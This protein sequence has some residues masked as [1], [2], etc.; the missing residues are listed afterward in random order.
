VTLTSYTGIYFGNQTVASVDTLTVSGMDTKKNSTGFV[1]ATDNDSWLFWSLECCTAT[2]VF[3]SVGHVLDGI[4]PSTFE[5][6]LGNGTYVTLTDFTDAQFADGDTLT[7]RAVRFQGQNMILNSTAFSI[8]DSAGLTQTFLINIQYYKVNWDFVSVDSELDLYSTLTNFQYV[9][10]NGTAITQ[11]S[12]F[13]NTFLG[14]GTLNPVTLKFKGQGVLVNNT[15]I[16]IDTAETHLIRAQWYKVGFIFASNDHVLNITP[17]HIQFLAPNG[18]VIVFTNDAHFAGHYIGNGTITPH[19]ITYKGQGMLKNQTAIVISEERNHLFNLQY[20]RVT[21]NFVSEDGILD[22]TPTNFKAVVANNTLTPFTATHTTLYLGNGTLTPHVITLHGQNIIKNMTGITIDADET[23]LMRGRYYRINWDFLSDSGTL[24]TNGDEP[25]NFIYTLG[26]ST[27][28]TQTAN[29]DAWYSANQ[30]LTPFSILWD[31]TSIH[32]NQTQFSISDDG[33]IAMRTKVYTINFV[34][35]STDDALTITPD[36]FIMVLSNGTEVTTT[37]PNRASGWLLA[38]GTLTPNKIG[39]QGTNMI[40]NATAITLDSTETH[41]LYMRYYPITFEFMSDD[42]VLTITPTNMTFTGA[43]GTQAT[44]TSFASAVY[45]G[46]Q[47]S[48]TVDSINFQNSDMKKNMTSLSI[49]GAGSSLFRIQYLP[50]K[51]QVHGFNDVQSSEL[52]EQ[53]FVFNI[54]GTNSLILTADNGSRTWYSGNGTLEM[55]PAWQDIR[56]GSNYS[57]LHSSSNFFDIDGSGDANSTIIIMSLN[58]FQANVGTF[59]AVWFAI[60]D[61]DIACQQTIRTNTTCVTFGDNRL[62][63][64]ASADSTKTLKLQLRTH[65]ECV[66]VDHDFITGTCLNQPDSILINTTLY[67]FPEQNWSWDGINKVMSFDLPFQSTLNMTIA[68][69][70]NAT[71]GSSDMIFSLENTNTCLKAGDLICTIT[72]PYTRA[73]SLGLWFYGLMMMMPVGMVWL[74]S[75]S[76]GP[77][78]ILMIIMIWIFGVFAPGQMG[79]AIL[80]PELTTFSYIFVALSIALTLW[81]LLKRG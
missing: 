51:A 78:F 26:N 13:I 17:D 66:S 54:N 12:D 9:A 41:L 56:A 65:P 50:V 53:I 5:F 4:Q 45:L 67:E 80:P 60:E 15:G 58:V 42:L 22:L 71:I 35:R 46:N 43:N 19:G 70:Q 18:T 73:G 64:S 28:V 33:T 29:M 55:A 11:N 8:N 30:T 79:T 27:V 24:L 3:A 40:L 52:I 7:P 37:I 6:D 72:S 59:P 57:T 75:Q 48:F 32:K 36:N 44:A 2:F 47:T 81:K 38:N 25:N 34:F 23:H 14:N 62:T 39:F 16:T 21:F 63:I 77:T 31:G 68:L 1:I 76:M 69:A 20:Y 61:T 49:S 74:R 10:P